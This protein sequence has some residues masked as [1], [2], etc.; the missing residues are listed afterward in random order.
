MS[1]IIV[2]D[3][4]SFPFDLCALA[5]RAGQI[6]GCEQAWVFIGKYFV[7]IIETKRFAVFFQ[8][9]SSFGTVYIFICFH[10]FKCRGDTASP[11]TG[12][13]R[14]RCVTFVPVVTFASCNVILF[15]EDIFS[16]ITVT[17]QEHITKVLCFVVWFIV[18]QG[19]FARSNDCF[20]CLVR[21]LE[22]AIGFGSRDTY[23][24]FLLD[25]SV[26]GNGT[27]IQ[28]SS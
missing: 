25:R 16:V 15:L 10:Q 11:T 14:E 1:L 6:Y 22:K 9:Q 2:F 7:W 24:S 5:R 19:I 20:R 26:A 4:T 13:I 8:L 3:D 18:I 23:K 27:G 28:S 21:C 12:T 17:F